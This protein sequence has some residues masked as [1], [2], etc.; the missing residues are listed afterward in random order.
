MDQSKGKPVPVGLSTASVW[1]LKAPAG[2]ELAA[3]LGYDGVE[4]MV[5]SDAV[6]QDV[7][8]L[9]RCARDTGMPV[10]SVHSPSLLITQRV[11][12]PDPVIRLRR[13]VEA[14][15]DLDARTVIVH[16]PFRWQR[17]YGDA[18][19]DLVNELEDASGVEIAVENMFKV[20][21][22]GGSRDSRVSAFRPSIDPTDVGYRHYTLDLSH[23][24]AAGMDSMALADRM[25]AGL[26]HV[27][28]AD[29]TGIPKDE[30]LVPGRGGQ[31][32]AELLETLARGGFDGQIVL[33][34]N[35]RHAVAPV[36]RAKDLAEALLFA[37]LHLGQ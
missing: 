8:A 23:T 30:H 10:L 34:I 28:L 15:V 7:S 31:P 21:P 26:R 9:R 18:F 13:T 29:G 14:A 32:C 16:P 27:H 19:L 37:R 4:V 12:S 17:R 11:W 1:P 5:W 33:E 22:P 24:A 36:Q 2:F 20:R 6:S 25:G 3:D 35:T